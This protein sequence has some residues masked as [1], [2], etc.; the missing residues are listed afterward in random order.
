MLPTMGGWRYSPPKMM[1]LDVEPV[2]DGNVVIEPADGAI[3]PRARTL[4]KG[5][6]DTLPEGTLRYKSHFAT[7]PQA[8][9]WRTRR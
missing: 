6:A 2:P 4:K 1:P 9:N 5:E 7:C 3:P 8:G